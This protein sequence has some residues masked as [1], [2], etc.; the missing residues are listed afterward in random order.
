MRVWA[1]TQHIASS[2][3]TT[4]NTRDNVEGEL[5][6]HVCVYVC[7]CVCMR[8]RTHTQHSALSYLKPDG[9]LMSIFKVNV[10]DKSS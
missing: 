1:H 5:Y 9:R 7:V 3:F 8:V 4:D 2:Y 6:N 10:E